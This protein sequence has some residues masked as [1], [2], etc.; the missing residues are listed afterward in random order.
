MMK[1][2][3]YS[4]LIFLISFILTV[5]NHVLFGNPIALDL[6]LNG[7]SVTTPVFYYPSNNTTIKSN[8]ITFRGESS[9]SGKVFIYESDVFGENGLLI[10][11]TTSNEDGNWKFESPINESVT[12]YYT[13]KSINVIN[14]NTSILYSDQ[15]TITLEKYLV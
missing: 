6:P 3:N 4:V 10:G 15:I 9:P 12:K 14:G 13:A 7:L 2:F 1:K 8:R 11:T 5:W